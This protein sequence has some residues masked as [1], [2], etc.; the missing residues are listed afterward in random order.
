MNVVETGHLVEQPTQ[1]KNFRPELFIFHGY[2]FVRTSKT[3]I[4]VWRPCVCD[5][6]NV[7]G[8]FEGHFVRTQAL[9]DEEVQR[10]G[11]KKFEGVKPVRCLKIHTD[12]PILC[13]PCKDKW[14]RGEALE[15]IYSNGSLI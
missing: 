9:S 11:L 7:V 2:S 14:L 10:H 5:N 1:V 4:E 6:C 3:I 13:E 12:A 8:A 15:K